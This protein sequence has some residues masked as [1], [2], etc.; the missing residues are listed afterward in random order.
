VPE[1][2]FNVGNTIFFGGE[3]GVDLNDVHGYPLLGQP[4]YPAKRK[5]CQ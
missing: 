1:D 2:G 4:K 3:F 5:P